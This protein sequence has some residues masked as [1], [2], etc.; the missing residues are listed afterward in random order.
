MI[1]NILVTGGAGYIGSV[2][3]EALLLKGYSVF[4]VDN[5]SIGRR[6][7]IA[8]SVPFFKENV[9]D[10]PKIKKI[11]TENKIDVVMHF[12]A[13]S[14]VGESITKPDKYFQNNIKCT[15]N[16]L[17]AMNESGC[18]K[19]IFSSTAAVYGNPQ[20]VPIPEDH[21]IKPINPYGMSK[22]V[23]EQSLAWFAEAYGFKYNI[24]RYF[25]AAGATSFCGEDRDIETHIIPILIDVANG[26]RE[27]FSLFGDD[28]NTPDGTCVR[29]YI[30]VS[31]LANAHILG[32]NNLE[33]NPA[34]IYNLGT[35]K[36][37]SNLEVVNMVKKLSGIDF[38]VSIENRRAGD[39]D[40]LVASADKANSELNWTPE[41][42]SLENIILTA[43]NN[44]LI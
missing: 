9:G 8:D 22:G 18:K 10:I 5:L 25:N 30:H 12:A 21:L 2:V 44:P 29:D 19:I 3:V 36:G 32:I 37:Y 42:S 40:E 24:F 34:A 33:K 17:H 41:K 27:K 14:L 28:Y 26:K 4:V 13:F 35:G 16:L 11:L 43:I 7:H 1:L 39:P 15:L 20:E 38:K 23:V 6:S 31:D